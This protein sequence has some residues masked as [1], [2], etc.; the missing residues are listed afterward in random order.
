LSAALLV[1]NALAAFPGQNGRIVFAGDDSDPSC[2]PDGENAALRT[3]NPDGSGIQPIGWGCAPAWSVN[4]A[5]LVFEWVDV[6]EDEAFELG[7]SNG[8][9]SGR[10]N[11]TLLSVTPLGAAWSPDGQ[12]VVYRCKSATGICVVNPSYTELRV[13]VPGNCVTSPAWSPDGTR[14]AFRSGCAG[15]TGILV[16]P[17][18]GGQSEVIVAGAFA[19]SPNWSPD[20]SRIVYADRQTTSTPTDL[21]SVH[22]DGSGITQ[23]TNTPSVG[24]VDPAWSPDGAQIVFASSGDPYVSDIYRM[25]ADGTNVTRLTTDLGSQ[26][27]WQP[28]P[29]NTAST[30]VRPAGASPFRASLVT[31][32]KDCAAPNR[33]HGPPLAYGSCAPPTPASSNLKVGVGDTSSSIGFVRF[34][35]MPGD[36]APPDDSDVQIQFRLSNVMR[37]ADLS[38]Y[39]G[40]LRASAQVR[41]T[42]HQ[43]TVSQTTV[44][45]PLEFDVPCVPTE[46][47]ATKSLCALTTTLDAVTPGAAAEGTRAVFALDQLKVYDGGAD[48]DA[49]TT[50]DNSLFAVQGV[51]VP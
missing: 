19:D 33:E 28:L 24:E 6:A 38:E 50:A 31:A 2:T 36:P 23:L 10:T 5:R 4:G 49:D 17:A 41:L 45:F 21:Y 8:D 43:G 27:D 30:H 13:V 37:S 35:V 25:N 47:T 11:I 16:V 42:D 46:S 26:P 51:F 1:D 39:T 20:G 14:I 22:A 32:F 40:E 48:E 7:F 29:V 34:R 3:M 9:G 44:D 15:Q 18:E 12:W